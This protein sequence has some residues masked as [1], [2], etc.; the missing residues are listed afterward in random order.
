MF[1]ITNVSGFSVWLIPSP[2]DSISSSDG[3]GDGT[4]AGS[5]WSFLFTFLMSAHFSIKYDKST[6]NFAFLALNFSISKFLLMQTTVYSFAFC[7]FYSFYLW[8]IF[9]SPKLIQFISKWHR[10]VCIF[11]ITNFYSFSFFSAETF[12]TQTRTRITFET[13]KPHFS[14]WVVDVVHYSFCRLSNSE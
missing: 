11:L 13:A 8:L 4:S 12:I 7:F 3:G 2:H 9:F 1:S 14:F 5:C 6:Q 10:Q